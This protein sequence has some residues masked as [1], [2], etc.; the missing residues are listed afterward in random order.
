MLF[1]FVL[2]LCL[3]AIRHQS[4]SVRQPMLIHALNNTAY[5]LIQM[6]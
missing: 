5:Y 4:G 6:G 1:A 3:G 2:G